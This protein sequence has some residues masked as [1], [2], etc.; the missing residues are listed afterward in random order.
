MPTDGISA[1]FCRTRGVFGFPA[2]VAVILA[3][4]ARK[5]VH[6]SSLH[7]AV[8]TVYCC[9]RVPSAACLIVPGA[10][11]F[12]ARNASEQQQGRFRQKLGQRLQKF[13]RRCAVFNP[14]VKGEAQAH[15]GAHHNGPV[16]HHGLFRHAA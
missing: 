15:H 2:N 3:Q 11:A 8:S 14:V 7:S 1:R 13:R 4:P 6:N 5:T 9:T 12:Q 10:R 16:T